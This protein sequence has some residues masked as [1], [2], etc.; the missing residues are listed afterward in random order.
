MLSGADMAIWVLSIVMD[1]FVC[2][3]MLIRGQG[4]KYAALWSYFALSVIINLSRMCVLM[5]CG[6]ASLEYAYWYYFSDVVFVIPLYFAVADLYRKMF[7]S[8]G[9]R[10]FIQWAKFLL[11]FFV[12]LYALATTMT[13]GRDL[14]AR[15][16]I[17][18]VEALLV[19]TAVL[20]LGLFYPSLWKGGAPVRVYQISFVLG[21]YFLFELARVATWNLYPHTATRWLMLPQ[22]TWTLLPFGIAYAFSH[23]DSGNDAATIRL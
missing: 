1:A 15:L 12:G 21:A 8:K 3:L 16:L 2:T 18:F 22:Y 13:S 20:A 7:R 5:Q 11:M 23:A 19:A 17:N 10:A 9:I 4:W 14:V 6:Y